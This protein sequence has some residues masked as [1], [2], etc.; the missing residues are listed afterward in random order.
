MK[1][2]SCLVQTVIATELDIKQERKLSFLC[3]FHCIR[4]III[5]NFYAI[6]KTAFASPGIIQQLYVAASY[7]VLFLIAYIQKRIK[8]KTRPLYEYFKPPPNTKHNLTQ[9]ADN[10][11]NL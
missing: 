6:D 11:E 2:I 7:T 4:V 1:Y 9:N 10:C 3:I 8:I 5:F